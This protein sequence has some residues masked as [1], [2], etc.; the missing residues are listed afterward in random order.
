[1]LFIVKKKTVKIPR[2]LRLENN[3]LFSSQMERDGHC[4]GFIINGAFHSES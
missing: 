1:M 4:Y 2:D 3:M